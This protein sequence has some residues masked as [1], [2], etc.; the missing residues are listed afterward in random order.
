VPASGGAPL[1]AT[2]VSV[3]PMVNTTLL[4]IGQQVADDVQPWVI[5]QELGT[6]SA[7][8]ALVRVVNAAVGAP[9]LH[10]VVGQTQYGDVRYHEASSYAGM[11]A[12]SYVFQ[13]TAAPPAPPLPQPPVF[14]FGAQLPNPLLTG[15]TPPNSPIALGY[16][17]YSAIAFGRVA[18][19]PY[20]AFLVVQD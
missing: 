8:G 17:F 14:T 9:G 4:A 15:V 10:V 19:D 12:G 18:R 11:E 2:T 6:A 16:N 13:A 7:G 20:L 1:I 5:T 3:S